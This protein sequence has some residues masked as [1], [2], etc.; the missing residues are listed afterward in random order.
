M[1]RYKE[2]RL[3]PHTLLFYTNTPN[4][5]FEDNKHNSLGYRGE[6]IEIEK[7]QGKARIVCIGGSTT[8]SDGVKDY[9]ESYPYLLEKDLVRRGINAEVINAGTP[10]YYTI[11]N[12]QNYYLK[13]HE[14]K[15]D[16][17]IIYHGINDLHTRLVWPPEYY[18]PDQ[19]GAIERVE[20]I[21]RSV[22]RFLSV[23]RVPLVFLDYW[24]SESALSS[25]VKTADTNV[26]QLYYEQL[27]KGTYPEGFFLNVPVDS[28]FKI[29]QPVYFKR[30]TEY[31]IKLMLEQGAEPIL[32]TFVYSSDFPKEA[33]YFRA[34]EFQQ[35]LA[36][37][38]QV[39]I[40]LSEQ[41]GLELI[42]LAK[43]LPIEKDMFTD[44][45]HFTA[46]GNK[47]RVKLISDKLTNIISR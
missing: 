18:K 15:P 45:V 14:L 25:M 19:S 40:D 36:Q 46:K 10:G 17:V 13:I 35:A 29:N 3:Q 30:N 41:Y 11:Q 32:S 38:N 24:A 27:R 31:M 20:Q 21:N 6:E 39:M 9:K 26:S 23:I 22:F 44:G 43:E 4:Y 34:I 33:P 47:L 2:P 28:I 37:H 8:Y 7:E 1:N 16:F 12:L 5:K 42:D